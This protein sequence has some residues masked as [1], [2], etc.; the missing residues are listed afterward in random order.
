MNCHSHPDADERGEL[1]SAVTMRAVR[2]G[3]KKPPV[4]FVPAGPNKPDEW[5]LNQIL[6]RGAW[7][8]PRCIRYQF[9]EDGARCKKC[10]DVRMKWNPPIFDDAP[11]KISAHEKIA[12]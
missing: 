2:G 6:E 8:C 4:R 3:A 7:F 1:P 9:A 12:A 11:K 5:R 10:A